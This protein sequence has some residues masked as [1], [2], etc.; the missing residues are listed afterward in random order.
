MAM[1]PDP[2]VSRRRL[3]LLGT[4]LSG[5]AVAAFLGVPILG[6]A[7]RPLFDRRRTVWRSLGPLGQ[8]PVEEPVTLHVD[9][10]PQPQSW[11]QTQDTWIVF[12][13]RYRDGSLKTFSNICTHMQCPV[14]WQPSV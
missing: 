4:Q 2:G 12:A 9:F 5:L 13:V 11:S 8:L 1:A 10:P 14:R 3:L 7:L 6:W